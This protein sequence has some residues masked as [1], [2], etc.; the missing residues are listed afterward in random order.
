MKMWNRSDLRK[1]LRT[2]AQIDHALALQGIAGPA[3]AH[4]YLIQCGI[5]VATVKRVLSLPHGRRQLGVI[6]LRPDAG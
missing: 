3:Q 1:D 6:S 4:S 5:P 2:A